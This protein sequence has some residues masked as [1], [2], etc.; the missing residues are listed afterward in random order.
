MPAS[1]EWTRFWY[2][3][4]RVK[5]LCIAEYQGAEYAVD[6]DVFDILQL[7]HP[8]PILPNLVCLDVCGYDKPQIFPMFIQPTLRQAR[9]STFC[10]DT[11]FAFIETRAPKLEK[12]VVDKLLC[13]EDALAPFSETICALRHLKSLDFAC[14]PLYSAAIVHL[15]SLPIFYRLSLELTQGNADAPASV[16]WGK[17]PTL[18]ALRLS[19]TT[20]LPDTAR[21]AAFLH[22]LDGQCLTRLSVTIRCDPRSNLDHIMSLD[23]L[24]AAIGDLGRLVSCRLHFETTD[25]DV[26]HVD[27]AI[28]S[29][30]WR[31]AFLRTFIL[32][33][34]P[35][36]FS[37]ADLRQ[38]ATAWP[39]IQRLQLLD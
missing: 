16:A 14:V 7:H 12:L 30:L 39:S 13:T 22:A 9:V 21:P 3:A 35:V 33:N 25:I 38:L 18:A 11:T 6:D 20:K 15:S 19:I 1:H 17:F 24:F 2:F 8:G 34:L 32:D 23:H 28:L 26:R 37:T 31:L 36:A 10:P 5:T 4:C 29:P 27:A